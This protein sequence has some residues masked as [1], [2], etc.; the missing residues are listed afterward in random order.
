[1]KQQRVA[2]PSSRVVRF[3]PIERLNLTERVYCVLKERILSQEIELGA[4]L[5]DEEL[6]A[7]LGVSR[8]P[9][10]EALMRLNREGL[11]DIVPRSGTMVRVFSESDVEDIYDVRIALE[12]LSARRAAKNLKPEHLRRLRQMHERAETAFRRRDFHPLLEFDRELHRLIVEAS[13]NR[14]LQTIMATINDFVSLF[15]NLGAKLPAHRGFNYRHR[16]IMQ[17]LARRDSEATA[18]ALGE[19]I[20]GAKEQL[21]RDLQERQV[22]KS[23]SPSQAP[24]LAPGQGLARGSALALT[25]RG[26][27]ARRAPGIRR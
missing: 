21:L 9:V 6:A 8:T 4:R 18:C 15:R 19:H 17:A 26:Q 25:R 16:E 2:D 3:E 27:V 5:R 11:V 24:P 23:L 20:E 14:K 13:G 22:L 12:S 1:M 10:R 7:Q